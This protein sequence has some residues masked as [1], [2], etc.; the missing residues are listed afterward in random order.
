MASRRG[1]P[2]SRRAGPATPKRRPKGSKNLAT[3]LDEKV[4]VTEVGRRR[5]IT[6]RELVIK[7]PVNKSAAADLRPV[8]QLPDIVQG[9]ERRAGT[10]Q[11]LPSPPASTAADEEVIGELR[12]RMERDIRAKIAAE[13]ADET[14]TVSRYEALLRADFAG[15][16]HR[17]FCELNP[18]AGFSIHWHFRS[19]RGQARR[20]SGRPAD[21]QTAVAPPEVAL[22]LGR[23][24]SVVSR[25]QPAH[26][27][28]L[29]Q[30][31]VGPCRQI[32]A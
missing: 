11:A 4:T 10:S 12:K 14:F 26:A 20:G 29:R 7:Q 6:K 15:F 31:C 27:D 9:A 24:S 5:R 19:D 3:L 30:L 21:H 1:T 22:G 28:S 13:Q 18:R 8:K 25:A 32:V 16:A 17:P 2:V 23:L